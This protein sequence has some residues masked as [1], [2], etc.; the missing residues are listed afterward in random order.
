MS[1]ASARRS[2]VVSKLASPGAAEVIGI[3]VKRNPTLNRRQVEMVGKLVAEFGA[4]AAKLSPAARERLARKGRLQ[5]VIEEIVAEPDAPP[6]ARL[7]LTP[8]SAAE[9]SQG[10]GLGKAI[11]EAEGQ[12]RLADYA[13]PMTAV[14]WAGPL[15]GPSQLEREFGIARSTLHAWQ[16][17][18]AVIAV[19]VGVRKH[20]FPIEQFIDGRPVSGLRPVVEAV[21]EMRAAWRWLREPNPGL[22]GVLP[23]AR[24]KN[25][26]L[27]SVLGVARSNFG[28]R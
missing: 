20:A 26:D 7:E 12:A 9:V 25:G 13:T 5:K 10:T 21:G 22:G 28:R 19:Q 8:Q 23:L 15:A 11:S 16:K 1:S 3:F 18:R 4:A 6:P 24:L 17:Q 14:G 2:A 27:E